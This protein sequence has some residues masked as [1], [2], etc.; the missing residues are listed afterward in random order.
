LIFEH[1]VLD[2]LHFRHQQEIE[3]SGFVTRLTSR[4]AAVLG[5]CAVASMLTISV[6][7]KASADAGAYAVGL[8]LAYIVWRG[9]KKK[10]A[11]TVIARYCEDTKTGLYHKC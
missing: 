4:G 8:T 6:P 11:Y 5:A 2:F 3:M 1:V 7:S 10:P 9:G